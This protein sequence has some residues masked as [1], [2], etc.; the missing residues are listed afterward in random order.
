MEWT[1]NFP[2]TGRFDLFGASAAQKLQLTE[3]IFQ[4]STASDSQSW[5]IKGAGKQPIPGVG[6]S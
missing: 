5:E 3:L 4:I 1:S 6:V 2:L